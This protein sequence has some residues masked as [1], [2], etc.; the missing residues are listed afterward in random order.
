MQADDFG[1]VVERGVDGII[2]WDEDIEGRAGEDTG[3][4]Q[5]SQPYGDKRSEE[6]IDSKH[7]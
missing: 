5:H 2:F 1:L 7:L 3:G 4:Q 6:R